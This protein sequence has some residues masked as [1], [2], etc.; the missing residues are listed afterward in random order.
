MSFLYKVLSV[1]KAISIQAHPDKTLAEKLHLD[2][3]NIY[4][5]PNAKPELAISLDNN[6][7]ACYGFADTEVI[8]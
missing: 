4:K 7:I 5:D 3:P 8:K 1:G 6:F 2:F